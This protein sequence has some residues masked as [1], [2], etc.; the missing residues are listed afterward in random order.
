MNTVIALIA[1]FVAWLVS[2]WLLVM[3]G[4]GFGTI[5]MMMSVLV[6]IVVFIKVKGTGS[7][8]P[9]K[10]PPGFVS[11]FAHDNIAIDQQN[12]KLW[13]R[14]KDGASAVIDKGDVLRWNVAYTAF[15]AVHIK[16]MLQVHVR[17]LNRPKFDVR[18]DRHGDRFKSGADRNYAEAQ[19][20]DSRLTTWINNT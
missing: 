6:G 20:W 15:G 17:D 4:I 9:Q 13:L 11:N 10:L 18:F 1:G 2:Y 19:E 8:P 12:A 16:N 7:T 5:G 14:D 3:L